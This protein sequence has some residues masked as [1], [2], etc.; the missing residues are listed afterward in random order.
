VK[1]KKLPKMRVRAQK[2]VGA[3]EEK[4]RERRHP[5]RY[6]D[7]TTAA[8]VLKEAERSVKKVKL[9]HSLIRKELDSDQISALQGMPTHMLRGGQID[10]ICTDLEQSFPMLPCAY[11]IIIIGLGFCRN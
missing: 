10:V 4:W 9:P 11:Q 1:E 8:K 6:A 2:E 3:A 5:A 7:A